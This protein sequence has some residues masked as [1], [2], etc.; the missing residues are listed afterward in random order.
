MVP[1]WECLS[2]ACLFELVYNQRG[3]KF[4][5]GLLWMKVSTQWCTGTMAQI[6]RLRIPWEGVASGSGLSTIFFKPTPA[7]SAVTGDEGTAA[8]SGVK[9]F[10]DA[11]AGLLPNNI[12]ITYP[13]AADVLNDVNGQLLGSV[14][15]TQPS[16][17]TG[18]DIATWAAPAGAYVRWET[19]VIVDGRR[20]RGRT[21]IVPLSSAEYDD[22][23]NL[24]SATITTLQSAANSM[25]TAAATASTWDYAVW[26]RPVITAGV[27]TR[28]GSSS[29]VTSALVRDFTAVLKSRRGS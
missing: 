3:N 8:V 14:A 25:L 22:S 6:G 12:S 18:T 4:P 21:Y 10:F 28:N 24:G 27:V 23:G 17:T 9:G 7:D 11:I 2:G 26:H 1:R 29:P 5:R 19:G 13:T 20:L 16:V 15:I